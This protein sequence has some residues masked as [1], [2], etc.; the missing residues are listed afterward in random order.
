MNPRLIKRTA[1]QQG[2]WWISRRF[3]LNDV[4]DERIGRLVPMGS[5]AA[6]IAPKFPLRQPAPGRTWRWYG[7]YSQHVLVCLNPALPEPEQSQG[8]NKHSLDFG[9][10]LGLSHPPVQLPPQDLVQPFV[11]VGLPPLAGFVPVRRQPVIHPVLIGAV[12]GR[13]RQPRLEPQKRGFIPRPHLK[14]PPPPPLGFG[15]HRRPNHSSWR[16][17]PRRQPR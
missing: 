4:Q 8:A 11:P 12:F 9:V 5:A 13:F 14:V 10:P 17:S 3:L 16:P 2:D 1:R 15:H 7:G 6:I